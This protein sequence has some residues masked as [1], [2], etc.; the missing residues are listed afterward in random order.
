MYETPAELPGNGPVLKLQART[1]DLSTR[2]LEQLGALRKSME[3]LEQ[4]SESVQQLQKWQ[5]SDLVEKL[6]KRSRFEAKTESYV[7]ELATLSA[8]LKKVGFSEEVRSPLILPTPCFQI[9][10]KKH[11]THQSVFECI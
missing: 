6:Q 8:K 9:S 3:E 10:F 11:C 7:E 5:L 4:A 2:L 1:E